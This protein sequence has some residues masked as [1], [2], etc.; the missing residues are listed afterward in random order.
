MQISPFSNHPL[1]E[2]TERSSELISSFALEVTEKIFIQLTAAADRRSG[3][4]VCKDWKLVSSYADKIFRILKW[5]FG[6][7]SKPGNLPQYMAPKSSMP[8]LMEKNIV[9]FANQPC[10]LNPEKALHE[11]SLLVYLGSTLLDDRTMTYKPHSANFGLIQFDEALVNTAAGTN[12]ISKPKW[13]T[14]H[15]Q[16]FGI[17]NDHGKKIELTPEEI[18]K[19]EKA[20]AQGYR[21]LTALELGHGLYFGYVGELINFGK[22]MDD[23]S[24]EYK[25]P[26]IL[27]PGYQIKY[28]MTIIDKVVICEDIE[29]DGTVVESYIYFQLLFGNPTPIAISKQEYE[30]NAQKFTTC[31]ML[32]KEFEA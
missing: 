9:Q 31:I 20:K 17:T 15:K 29:E 25:K 30:A 10:P 13:M 19:I 18:E 27:D 3:A 4:C 5:P 8:K 21:K 7:D 24:P 16:P 26:W 2:P 6:T 28:D 32:G 23:K 14:I 1:P 22:P 11:T 12:T